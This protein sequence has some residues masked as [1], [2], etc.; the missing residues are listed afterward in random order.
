MFEYFIFGGVTGFSSF[1]F[2]SK[3]TMYSSSRPFR[4]PLTAHSYAFAPERLRR[5]YTHGAGGYDYFIELLIGLS[6]S[7]VTTPSQGTQ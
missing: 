4:V 7:G 2:L 6:K 1:Y 3:I 5:P